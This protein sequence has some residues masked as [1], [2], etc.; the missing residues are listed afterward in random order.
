MLAYNGNMKAKQS[1]HR[2]V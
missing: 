1:S 2:R